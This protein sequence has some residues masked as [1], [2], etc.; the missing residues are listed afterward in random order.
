ME[1]L[2]FKQLEGL[3][4]ICSETQVLRKN[5]REEEQAHEFNLVLSEV[6]ADLHQT[7]LPWKKRALAI[8]I[9][10]TDIP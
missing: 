8:L 4:E 7:E 5:M 1:F 9:C 10:R 6:R 2:S 3:E